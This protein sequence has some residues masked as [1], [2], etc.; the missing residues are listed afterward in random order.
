M[1]KACTQPGKG[2]GRGLRP[3]S[4]GYVASGG[5]LMTYLS[6][7]GRVETVRRMEVSEGGCCAGLA[8]WRARVAERGYP[9]REGWLG[10]AAV[11][12]GQ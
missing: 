12:K 6:A 7:P 3:T 1:P 5:A 2:G 10:R 9:G 4:P 8:S 11:S